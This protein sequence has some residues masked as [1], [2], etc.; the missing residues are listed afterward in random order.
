MRKEMLRPGIPSG[1]ESSLDL[2]KAVVP[3]RKGR[4]NQAWAMLPW[5]SGLAVWTSATPPNSVRSTDIAFCSEAEGTGRFAGRPGA[6]RAK[7]RVRLRPNRGFPRRTRLGRHP[8]IIHSS[9]PDLRGHWHGKTEN[10]RCEKFNPLF[11]RR[12]MIK[13][14]GREFVGLMLLGEAKR[15]APPYRAGDD[16]G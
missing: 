6:G 12:E 13:S 5:P 7:L 9:R 10:A 2:S 1:G 3:I 8:P 16:P 11:G 14:S 4:T 15:E